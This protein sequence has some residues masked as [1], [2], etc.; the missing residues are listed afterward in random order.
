[1]VQ[2]FIRLASDF[3]NYFFEALLPLSLLESGAQYR[4]R[5]QRVND[6][7]QIRYDSVTVTRTNRF[8][9]H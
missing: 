3:R 6:F 4:T 2:C 1:M 5:A 8:L 9:P 7:S